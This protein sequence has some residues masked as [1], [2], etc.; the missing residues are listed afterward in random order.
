MDDDDD[1]SDDNA[2]DYDENRDNNDVGADSN[3]AYDDYDEKE[4]IIMMLTS[5]LE[6]SAAQLTDISFEDM[7]VTFIRFH[8]CLYLSDI[9]LI[10]VFYLSD[11]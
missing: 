9:C 10:F 1:D 4:A 3:D 2:V 11:I 7:Q 5:R 8:I 6:R